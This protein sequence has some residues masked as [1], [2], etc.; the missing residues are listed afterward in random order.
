MTIKTKLWWCYI[1]Q[2]CVICNN[3]ILEINYYCKLAQN[4][5]TFYHVLAQFSFTANGTRLLS[6]ESECTSCLLSFHDV[7]LKIVEN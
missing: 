1:Y 7:R 4:I 6:P 5:C 3:D 2:S